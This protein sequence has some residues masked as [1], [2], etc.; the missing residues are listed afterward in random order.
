MSI[1]T[2]K[3]DKEDILSMYPKSEWPCLEYCNTMVRNGMVDPD[4]RLE[5]WNNKREKPE[6]DWI[7]EN[8]GVYAAS[9]TTIKKTGI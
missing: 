7:V 6:A 4:S 1:K 3:I 8:V 9:Y 2:I 5:V